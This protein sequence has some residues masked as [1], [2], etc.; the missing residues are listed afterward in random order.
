MLLTADGNQRQNTHDVDLDKRIA[1]RL[2]TVVNNCTINLYNTND[3]YLN[4]EKINAKIF[5][6]L[7]VQNHLQ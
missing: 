3:K 6:P 5:A 7:H 4:E 2:C 1:Y